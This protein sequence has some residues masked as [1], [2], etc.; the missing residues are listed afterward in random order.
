VSYASGNAKPSHHRREG[1]ACHRVLLRGY[2][3]SVASTS[4]SLSSSAG[5]T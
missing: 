2:S 3:S 5:S 4:S 1:S